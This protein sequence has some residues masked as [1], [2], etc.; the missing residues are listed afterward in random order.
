MPYKVKLQRK[1]C[2]RR[3]AGAEDRE[4]EDDDDEPEFCKTFRRDR[5]SFSPQIPATS[6]GSGSRGVVVLSEEPPDGE[7]GLVQAPYEDVE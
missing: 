2:E 1:G 5:C 3:G 7:L 4:E 6:A